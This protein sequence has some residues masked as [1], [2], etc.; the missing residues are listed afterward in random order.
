MLFGIREIGS[1]YEDFDYVI[2]I[3]AAS[4]SIENDELKLADDFKLIYDYNRAS[5]LK[6]GHSIALSSLEYDPYG[7]RLYMLTS[8]EEGDTDKDIG[9][10]LWTLSLE[11][12]KTGKEPTLVFDR[13]VDSTPLEFV[14]KPEGIAV[15]GSNRVLVIHDDDRVLGDTQFHR[16]ANQAAYNIV[17]FTP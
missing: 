8:F 2:K 6:L 4:Y 11:D 12:L 3:V 1:S 7:D 14:H 15:I 9:G 5:E 13:E 16:Q 10:F 17:E